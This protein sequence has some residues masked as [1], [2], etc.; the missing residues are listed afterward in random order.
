MVLFIEF[1]VKDGEV[2][3]IDDVDELMGKFEV[4]G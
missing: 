1:E 3:M 4:G 2:S